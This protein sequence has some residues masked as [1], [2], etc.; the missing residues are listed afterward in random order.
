M[1]KSSVQW[2]PGLNVL[3][4]QLLDT[5]KWLNPILSLNIYHDIHCLRLYT[6]FFNL[7]FVNWI[8]KFILVIEHDKHLLQ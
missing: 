3:L 6:E 4:N 1:A 2:V 5:S 7:M 8:Y